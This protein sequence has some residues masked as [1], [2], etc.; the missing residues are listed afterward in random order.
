[1]QAKNRVMHG[2][3]NVVAAAF[4]LT[5]TFSVATQAQDVGGRREVPAE[6]SAAAVADPSWDTPRT[7][8]GHP[9][10]EG[11]WSTDDMRSVPRSRPDQY[12]TRDRLTEEEFAERAESD[13]GRRNRA[14][15][16]E[17]FAA[18]SEWGIR[19]FGYTSQIID[20][21]NG[22]IPAM[23]E[24]ALARAAG[25]DRGTFGPGPFDGV[26]DFTLYDR[27]I[28]RGILGSKFP[29]VYGN[30]LQI[31]QSP[32]TVAITYEMIHDTRVIRLDDRP[33]VDQNMRQYL[34]DSKGYW[35][36]DTLVVETR[37]LTDQTSIGGNGNGTRHS[38][39]MIIVERFTRVD[40]EMI[41]YV[42]VVDDPVTYESPFTVR[43]MLTTQPNYQIWEYNCH[44]GNQAVRNA[45]S[46]ERTYEREAAAALARGETPPKRIPSANNLSSLPEEEAAFFD[47]N[48]GE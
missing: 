31:V 19:S 27:C 14:L 18:R 33:Y 2:P 13:A 36:G 32:N 45:L 9:S 25:R 4:C 29:V 37:N 12:G 8:W 6:M 48:A 15:N 41:E 17:T 47:I 23:T 5:M 42:A 11:I 39:E 34:G 20:P 30:G 46:G 24:A 16:E 43:L 44:E 35:D 38:T 28:T 3:R 10:F 22:Q 26:N 1:M 40:P 7:S 21:P